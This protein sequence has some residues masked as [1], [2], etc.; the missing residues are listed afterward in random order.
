MPKSAILRYVGYE[1]SFL[2][3]GPD[4]KTAAMLFVAE[5]NSLF[6]SCALSVRLL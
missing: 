3:H 1:M 5:C 4:N 6:I 2:S